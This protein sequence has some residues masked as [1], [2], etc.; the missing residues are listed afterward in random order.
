MAKDVDFDL[1]EIEAFFNRMDRAARGEFKKAVEVWLD[2]IGVD[3]LRVVQD[4]VIRLEVVDTRLL[5]NS[6][7]KGNPN[8]VWKKLER[9]LGLQLGSNIK[10]S[11]FVNTGHK[12]KNGQWWEGYHY[13]DNAKVMFEDIFNEALENKLQEWLNGTFKD[14]I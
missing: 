5:L 9:G 7:H 3:F 6:F 11:D 13:F 2:A 12:L 4:E 8:S 14:F 10:Y 1:S